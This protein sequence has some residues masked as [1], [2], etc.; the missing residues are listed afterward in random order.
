LAKTSIDVALSIAGPIVTLPVRAAGSEAGRRPSWQDRAML[1]EGVIEVRR[2]VRPG[3]MFRLPRRGGPDG[4]TRSRRGV[5]HRLLH[6]PSGEPVFVRV[7]QPARDRVLFGAQASEVDEAEWGIERMRAALGVDQDLRPF[8]ERFR[9]DAMIGRSVRDRPELRVWGKPDAFEALAWAI[10]E[11]L[12]ELQEATAIERRIVAVLGRRCERTGLRN[13]PSAGALAGAAPAQ[14]CSLG[15]SESRAIALVRVARDVDRGRIRLD[16]GAPEEG[17][18]RLLAIRGIGPWTVQMLALTG[19]GRMDQLPAGDLG[20][21]KWV[22]RL[23]SGGDPWARAT[24][25][26]VTELFAPYAPWSGLAGF[27]AL[28]SSTNFS[29]STEAFERVRRISDSFAKRSG[30]RRPSQWTRT[31]SV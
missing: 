29:V 12:I 7:A 22:G 30:S 19:Q 14:L 3:W 23:L 26:E 25:E 2:E 5:L 11:Q 16:S 6:A 15:L 13:S 9:F 4:L 10:C 27:H 20:Y 18:R 8:Y 21:L 1:P 28:R 17:W 24:V 31:V